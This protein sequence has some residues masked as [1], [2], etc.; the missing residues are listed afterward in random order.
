VGGRVRRSGSGKVIRAGRLWRCRAS[1]RGDGA[2][3]GAEEAIGR[4]RESAAAGYGGERGEGRS[5]GWEEYGRDE[6]FILS[7]GECGDVSGRDT[8][9]ESGMVGRGD[10]HPAVDTRPGTTIA[11][12]DGVTV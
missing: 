10:I 7:D 3:G 8:G 6:R 2:H 12:M 1:I 11:S 4:Q 9:E 5:W